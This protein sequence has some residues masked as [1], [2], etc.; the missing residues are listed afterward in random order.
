MAGAMDMTINLSAEDRALLRDIAEHLETL[1]AD[2]DAHKSGH[3][4]TEHS[5]RS[6]PERWCAR[7]ASSLGND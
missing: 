1:R 6:T 2:L 5:C 7:C 4:E 3:Y